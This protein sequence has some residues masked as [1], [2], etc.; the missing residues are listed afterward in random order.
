MD[1]KLLLLWREGLLLTPALQLASRGG[2]HVLSLRLGPGLSPCRSHVVVLHSALQQGLWE[3]CAVAAAQ[4]PPFVLRA[5]A[6]P[7]LRELMVLP[8][9]PRHVLVVTHLCYPF[10]QPHI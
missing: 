9:V 1:N 6:A 5:A 7:G 10:Q 8:Q 3:C 2:G 4:P